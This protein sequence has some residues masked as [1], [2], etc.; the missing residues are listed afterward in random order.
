MVCSVGEQLFKQFLLVS[1]WVEKGG[2][3][4]GGGIRKPMLT[5]SLLTC[6][7]WAMRTPDGVA[8]VKVL[9]KKEREK[10]RC[11]V[12][13]VSGRRALTGRDFYLRQEARHG[14]RPGAGKGGQHD[15]KKKSPLRWPL[16]LQH[17]W[18]GGKC[19]AR[20]TRLTNLIIIYDKWQR[21]CC[22]FIYL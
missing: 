11:R 20:W 4:R 18:R 17:G 1:I 22:F 13:D 8:A 9:S 7:H 10:A 19:H 5:G 14:R 3:G 12:P 16:G 15:M 2:G 21:F 6:S